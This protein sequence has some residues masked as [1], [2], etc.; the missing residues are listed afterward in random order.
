[1]PLSI[2]PSGLT[3]ETNA[4]G[5]TLFI[6]A[7][8]GEMLVQLTLVDNCVVG[9][10]TLLRHRLGRIRDVRSDGSGNIYVL[11]EDGTLYRL[12]RS[13]DADEPNKRRL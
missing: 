4:F 8:A 2:A 10:K 7:L 6:G 9:E 12:E 11:A 13:L 1:V 5:T 3:V